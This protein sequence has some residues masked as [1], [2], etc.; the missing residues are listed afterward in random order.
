M[1]FLWNSAVQN[2]MRRDAS[3]WLQAHGIDPKSPS[4]QW[5]AYCR[6]EQHQ[7]VPENYSNRACF[8]G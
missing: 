7:L 6:V 4:V 2:W 8:G 3:A 1:D 5:F